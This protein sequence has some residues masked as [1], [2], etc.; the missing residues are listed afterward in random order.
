[1]AT[2]TDGAKPDSFEV[3]V[4][5]LSEPFETCRL[6]RDDGV[7]LVGVWLAR[8]ALDVCEPQRT[9]VVLPEFSAR[10]IVGI[11]TINGIEQS[12]RFEVTDGDTVVSDL[13]V[14][15]YPIMLRMSE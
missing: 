6:L 3:Q 5:G 14:G 12:L 13:L 4:Q 11:D 2:V 7:R 1:M 10:D 8:R 15:D 9:T